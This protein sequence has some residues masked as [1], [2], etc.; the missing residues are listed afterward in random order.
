MQITPTFV[1]L[2]FLKWSIAIKSLNNIDND[3]LK[4]SRV[5]RATFN[6]SD[7]LAGNS[8]CNHRNVV[9]DLMLF[10]NNG[11][12]VQDDVMA[13]KIKRQINLPKAGQKSLLIIFDGTG[14]MCISS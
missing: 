8:S 6:E 5:I 11:D 9:V 14:S 7:I 10:D 1:I 13:R 2:I 3:E 12:C 4:F